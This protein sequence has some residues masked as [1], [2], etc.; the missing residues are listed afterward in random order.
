M[1]HAKQKQ[2]GKMKEYENL[3]TLFCSTDT[4]H[5]A[6]FVFRTSIRVFFLSSFVVG[7]WLREGSD[8]EHKISGWFL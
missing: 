4:G 3:V 1:V 6:G 7:R 8:S 5:N 2:K